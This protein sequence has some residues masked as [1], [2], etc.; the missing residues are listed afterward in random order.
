MANLLLSERDRTLLHVLSH[1]PATTTLLARASETLSEEG[2]RDGD[3][4][5]ERLRALAASGFVR[6]FAATR[7]GGGISNYYK[8]TPLGWESIHAGDP[9]PIPR[10]FFAECSPSRFS[11]TFALA[12]VIVH[13][14]VVCHQQRVHVA[15]FHRENELTITGGHL[16]VQPDCVWQFSTGGRF[17]NI[18]FE[19]DMG[20]EP[21][22]S[23]RERSIRT[24]ILAYEAHQDAALATWKASGEVGIRPAFR[25]AF[26]TRT[27]ER[28]YHILSLATELARNPKR[29][30]VYAITQDAYLVENNAVC[31]PLFLCHRGTWQPLVNLH[32]TSDSMRSPVRIERP[33]SAVNCLC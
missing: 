12:E 23:H 32:P 13:T 1:T 3:R 7:P 21:I 9:P 11:H 19:L 6:V 5:R 8:L 24:K 28:A 26:L 29:R 20:T 25:V 17:F 31:V 16:S 33:L 18:A 14:L 15:R 30:L 27:V 22:Q 10:A 4:L 2:F